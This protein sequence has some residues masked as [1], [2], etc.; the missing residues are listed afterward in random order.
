[1]IPG[2]C[3]QCGATIEVDNSK[4]TAFC[5]YCGTKFITET[6]INNYSVQ[7]A[8]VQHVDNINIYHG[9]TAESITERAFIALSDGEFEQA[10]NN[11]LEALNID[12]HNWSAYWGLVLCDRRCLNAKE[13]KQLRTS[14]Y[15]DKNF[16]HALEYA[17][18]D[19][20][21]WLR[22]VENEIIK[23]IEFQ[24]LVKRKKEIFYLL[25]LFSI[26]S[27]VCS[28][29]LIGLMGS[30]LCLAANIFIQK[31]YGH[32]I[33]FMSLIGISCIG[34]VIFIAINH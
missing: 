33:R 1:M 28:G 25:L 4:E 2:I 19:E 10:N 29:F 34:I 11:F 15:N 12:P 23:N 3:T 21:K 16:V 32:D 24:K 18:D 30:I 22:S 20:Q 8:T 6:A 27:C 17:P 7:N 9:K 5:P 13:A 26:I 31:K 14:L